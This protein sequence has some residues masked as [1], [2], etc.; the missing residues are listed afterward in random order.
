MIPGLSRPRLLCA[1]THTNTRT[2]AGGR[3]IR[4]CL[5]VP[6]T[7][8]DP[9]TPFSFVR[10]SVRRSVRLRRRRHVLP[11][12][13]DC[14]VLQSNREACSFATSSALLEVLHCCAALCGSR[15]NEGTGVGQPRHSR[16]QSAKTKQQTDRNTHCAVPPFIFRQVVS[17]AAFGEAILSRLPSGVIK[18]NGSLLERDPGRRVTERAVDAGY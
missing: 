5:P 6:R 1:H 8:P 3:F 13:F 11:A 9:L 18:G 7:A 4:P 10:R 16:K 15:R 12:P 2:H 17:R 14:A